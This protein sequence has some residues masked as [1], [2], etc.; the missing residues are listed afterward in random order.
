L[1]AQDHAA[2]EPRLRRAIELDPYLREAYADLAR[3]LHRTDRAEEAAGH[4]ATAARLQDY[5]EAKRNMASHLGSTGDPAPPMLMGEIELTE[6]RFDEAVNW[7]LRSQ[8]LGGVGTRSL[9]GLAEALY[10]LGDTA[11]G[12]VVMERVGD[13]DDPRLD[14][15]GAAR[16]VAQG[17]LAGSAVLIARAVERGP[18]EREFLR[19]AADL[20]VDAGQPGEAVVL[21]ER[22]ASAPRASTEQ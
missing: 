17:D 3:L 22:A 4:E 12:D 7:F 19:R 21:L 14:L 11:R 20:Y 13:A 6:R 5:E 2:A 1:R 8:G 16:L 10:R 18:E 15:A 9:A